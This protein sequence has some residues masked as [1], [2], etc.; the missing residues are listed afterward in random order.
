MFT[1]KTFKVSQLTFSI[2]TDLNINFGQF[3]I[4]KCQFSISN[5]QTSLN[6][7]LVSVSTKQ[8]FID[9]FKW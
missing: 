6:S 2:S 1:D 7:C 5:N 4:F 9:I 8:F 3:S